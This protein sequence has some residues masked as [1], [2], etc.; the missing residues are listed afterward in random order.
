MLI[1]DRNRH[2]QSL[3]GNYIAK[4]TRLPFKMKKYLNNI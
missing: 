1:L 3:N 2:L 4:M